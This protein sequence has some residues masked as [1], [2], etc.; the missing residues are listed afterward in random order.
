[1]QLSLQ[2]RHVGYVTVI[3]CRGRI[4]LGDEAD[5][6][7]KQIDDLLPINSRILLHL[8][9]VDFIDSGGLGLLVRCLTRVQNAAGQLSICA[10]S[11]KV[12]DVLRVTRLDGVLKPYFAE[13]DAI[14]S[15]H[16]DSHS[17]GAEKS[18]NAQILCVDTSADLLVYLR[19]LLKEAGHRVVTA[20]NLHDGLIL[21]KTV[22]P[23]VVVM[24]SALH[25][26]RG[27]SSAE[28]FHRRLPQNGLVI[29][30]SG[31]S[32]RDAGEAAGTL[33]TE[34]R[35]VLDRGAVSGR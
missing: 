2:H 13:A 4:V 15:A 25:A 30:P 16:S 28:E 34:V 33:L 5:A 3:T 31:F 20:E 7:L 23:R 21:L 26:L 1:V 32:S 22:Q 24:G 17:S 6:L 29:L 35:L 14:A 12:S 8:G 18:A 27:T 9:D 19:G 10:L 11:P